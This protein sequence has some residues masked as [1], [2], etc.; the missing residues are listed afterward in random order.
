MRGTNTARVAFVDLEWL[1][2]DRALHSIVSWKP[3]PDKDI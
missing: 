3:L 1:S 2:E